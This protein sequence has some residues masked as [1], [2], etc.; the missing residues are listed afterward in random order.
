MKKVLVVGHVWPEPK[1]TAAGNRMLQLLEAFLS[2][3]YQ[4]TFAC[5]AA[6][7]AHSHNLKELGITEQSISLNDSSFDKWVKELRPHM[8]IFDRFMV[9][10]QF[11]W[12]IALACPMAIRILNTEDLHSLREYRKL[13]A[14][15]SKSFQTMKWLQRDKTKRECASI[16]RSD[17]TLVISAVEMKILTEDLKI[18]RNLLWHLP[19]LLERIDTSTSAIFPTFKER[20]GFMIVGN[21]KHAPNVDAMT[22]LRQKIWPIIR[23]Q[24]P[25][26][27]LHVYGA[28]LPQRVYD[29]KNNALGFFVHGQ[30]NDI[31]FEIRRR[32]LVLAP[33]RFGA[34]IKG[35][36]IKAMQNGTPSVTTSIGA[37]GMH[38]NISWPGR[39]A[40]DSLEFA[41][42]AI[43]LYQSEEEWYDAQLCGIKIINSLYE[44]QQLVTAFFDRLG[45][46]EKSL[47][48]HRSENFIGAILQHQSM[49]ATTYMGKWIEEKNKS[50]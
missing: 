39:V 44:K 41:Q 32:R 22:Y 2:Q 1:T 16:F 37:E 17:I 4:I 18:D 27:N 31:D 20:S 23:K 45:A 9:E 6:K 43:E 8:V 29:L 12:R 34:G 15:E 24:L 13:C 49:A 40:N 28:Y 42:S 38:G 10:E 7:T 25:K 11:G 50:T 21:G 26:A 30:V 46:L 19:F 14:K 35:K 48:E 33:L 3:S 47:D 5:V 36:L